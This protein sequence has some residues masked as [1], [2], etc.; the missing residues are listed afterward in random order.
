MKALSKR[1]ISL[2]GAVV[3]AVTALQA[4]MEVQAAPSAKTVKNA[5]VTYLKKQIS[6]CKYNEDI[7]Y[8]LYDFNKD[9]VKELVVS[10][11]EKGRGAVDVYTYRNKKVVS[12]VKGVSEAGY[13]KGKKYLV[14]YSS[15]GALDYNYTVY[16]ISKGKLVKVNKYAC[17]RGVLKKDGKK[18]TQSKF[19]TFTKKVVTNLGTSQQIAKKYYTP[20]KLG[21]SVLNQKKPYTCITKA[22]NSKVYYYTYQIGE[23][24]MYTQKSKVKSAKITSKTKFYYGD[25]TLLFS[26]NLKGDS[27]DTKKWIYEVSKKQFIKKME[28]YWGGCDRIIVK[29]G[30]VEKVIIHIQV[31][32]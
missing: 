5:Y 7:D 32:G 21:I 6:N 3:L 13:I 2:L 18:I 29:N 20:K 15:G 10:D 4:P 30:K 31:A 12:L 23:E 16:K 14:T 1:I 27:M 17:V 11:E 9:G 25:T 28:N 24:G 19:N 8:Y 22:N 26:G